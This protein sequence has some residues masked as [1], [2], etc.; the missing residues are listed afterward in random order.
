MALLEIATSN[1]PPALPPIGFIFK[2]NPLPDDVDPFFI[3]V[4]DRP[5]FNIIQGR[6]PGL[7]QI[8]SGDLGI[9]EQIY[10]TV[11]DPSVAALATP[12]AAVPIVP[13]NA[14]GTGK[15]PTT[16]NTVTSSTPPV[17]TTTYG[18]KVPSANTPL[19]KLNNP[20]VPVGKE[21]DIS[22]KFNFPSAGSSLN[23]AQKALV[24]NVV[25]QDAGL[26]SFEKMT[27]QSLMEAQKP[28]L[29]LIQ[30]FIAML[31]V[32][33]DC[34][35]RFLG[36]SIKI[37]IVNIWVG[38]PSKNPTFTKGSLNYNDPKSKNAS[39]IKKINQQGINLVNP[40]FPDTK[41]Y[42]GIPGGDV[43]DFQEFQDNQLAYYIG[44]FDEDGAQVLP[45]T[46]VLNS[47]K[48]FGKKFNIQNNVQQVE[49]LSSDLDQ[50]VSQ[51]RARYQTQVDRI[52]IEREKMLKE[53]DRQYQ[54]EESDVNR[55]TI[56]REKEFALAK[57]DEIK[58][59]ALDGIDQTLY[60]EWFTKNATAQIKNLYQQPFLSTVTPITDSHG[61]PVEPYVKIPSVQ[62]APGINV[63]IPV[64][65][66]ENQ[67]I[68][69]QLHHNEIDA[70][71]LEPNTSKIQ[72][73]APQIDQDLPVNFFS[74]T[75][76]AATTIPLLGGAITDAATAKKYRVPFNVKKY[77]LDWDYEVVLDYEIR[78]IQTGKVLRTEEE[79][80]PARINFERDYQLRL[81]RINNVPL[82][83]SVNGVPTVNKAFDFKNLKL[84][85]VNP[86][87]GTALETGNNIPPVYKDN[88]DNNTYSPIVLNEDNG[89]FEGEV[90]HGLDPR[91]VDAT[92]WKTFWMVEAIKKDANGDVFINGKRAKQ[93]SDIAN[94]QGSGG[95]QWYGL[96]DKF[97]VI[98]K[99][100]GG[101][102]PLITSKFLPLLVK[103]V[104]ILTNP[105][106]II[107][108]VN[109]IIQDKLNKFFGMFN[110]NGAK[111]KAKLQTTKTTNKGG[112]A[113]RYNYKDSKGNIS[114]VM[115][116]KASAKILIADVG[117]N[118][119]DGQV[120]VASASE[121]SNNKTKDQ[122]ILKFILN[123][124]KMPFDIIKKIVDFFMNLVPKLLNPFTLLSTV[125]D[126]LTFKWLIDILSPKTVMGSL[127]NID[128]RFL[129]PDTSLESD[130]THNLNAINPDKMFSDMR[131][132][133]HGGDK[134]LVEVFVYHVF[135]GT[136]FLREEIVE[137]PLPDPLIIAQN[138][139]PTTTF[140]KADLSGIVNNPDNLV[141]SVGTADHP[142]Q[143]T[144]ASC[145]PRTVNINALIPI[146][147]VSSMPKFNK[148]EAIQVFL[149]PVELVLGILKLIEAFV[150][151]V[152]SIP[153]TVL[154]L[155][156]HITFP[157]LNFTGTLSSF[158]DGLKKKYQSN[159]TPPISPLIVPKNAKFLPQTQL[160]A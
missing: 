127:G 120:K 15:A 72:I 5:D 10:S 43:P 109:L 93:P 85:N 141:G 32:I 91:F 157:K 86:T 95:K 20:A 113:S 23:A 151:A 155:E 47:N 77:F 13:V 82:S 143:P 45:P 81:I 100:V 11:L 67:L 50:G 53:Y 102:L 48:W 59:S 27:I 76:P 29:E 121:L 124:I 142:T 60:S 136:Q 94:A 107:E 129:A 66:S 98:A 80:I 112:T 119:K 73:V 153:L 22:K 160:F 31:A 126:L 25:P 35:A 90:F 12:N 135:K 65:E 150:N 146:P 2:L 37:P 144:P 149:K 140:D 78:S 19:P 134:G 137:K 74:H 55:T 68:K 88:T 156:P 132:A 111:D 133:M 115:D 154:G 54:L 125:I 41:N 6:P 118:C 46:W 36:T 16:S 79:I 123:L 3:P 96:L 28:T 24:S 62:F 110:A 4:I 117:L 159:I 92:R 139:T 103:L 158:V 58:K 145:G 38:V 64:V 71:R 152:I 14:G 39:Y 89:L 131:A 7:K 49:M 30:I 75:K 9:T 97:T 40:S 51:L 63:E 42:G 148:C 138:Q 104:Q 105:S 101:L 122:P 34:I 70:I 44:Y 61:N 114:N 8:V 52:N 116:G 1:I 18:I 147:A 26:K 57:Y 108:L 87:T 99:L 83:G 33:E 21:A 130:L 106:K 84:G 128:P 56:L 69:N 17:P